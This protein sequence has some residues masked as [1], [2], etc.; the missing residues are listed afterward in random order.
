MPQRSPIRL[1]RPGEALA[2]GGWLVSDWAAG[3]SSVLSWAPDHVR[4]ARGGVE[5]VLDRAP[6]G[7][8]RP[9]A[10]GEVQT[11]ASAA[12]GTWRWAARA[13]RMASGAVFGMFAYRADHG[14]QPWIEFDWEFVGAD[15][16]RARINAH[17]ERPGGQRVSWEQ[18][19]GWRPVVAEL[20]FDAAE[21]VH[22]Y[23]VA[24]AEGGAV[25]R[26]D[27]REV[28]RVGP[29]DMPGGAWVRGEMRGFANLWCADEA[30]EGWAGRWTGAG[31]LVARLEAMEVE[32]R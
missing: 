28:G 13:P 27:G 29:R 7:A 26:V 31:P 8:A 4:A 11:L 22:L 21:A 24:V 14:G 12:L 5:L 2:E 15:T 30:L 32:P 23:E 18:G 16:R 25:F 3:Q 9:Y 20:G 1:I 17:M 19:R 10:G 6:V